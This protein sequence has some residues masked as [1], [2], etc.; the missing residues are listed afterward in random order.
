[1]NMPGK[2][3]G[4]VETRHHDGVE[5]RQHDDSVN[6]G[7]VDVCR[8]VVVIKSQKQRKVDVCGL[9]HLLRVRKM[10]HSTCNTAHWSTAHSFAVPVIQSID[11]QCTHTACH[12]VTELMYPGNI[13]VDPLC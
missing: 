2:I 1:M 4:L 7:K 9:E 13:R 10:I 8:L 12:A 3:I 5:N 11:C 6:R